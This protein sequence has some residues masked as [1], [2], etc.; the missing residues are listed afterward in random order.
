MLVT[1]PEGCRHFLVPETIGSTVSMPAG[2]IIDRCTGC[3]LLSVP[4]E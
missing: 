1:L 3:V 2:E 4:A